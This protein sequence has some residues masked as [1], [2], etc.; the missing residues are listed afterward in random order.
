[1]G[2]KQAIIVA[3]KRKTSR[4]QIGTKGQ[5]ETQCETQYFDYRCDNRILNCQKIQGSLPVPG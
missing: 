3:E 2:Q 5:G 1:M 4:E